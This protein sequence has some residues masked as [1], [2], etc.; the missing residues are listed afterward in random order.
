M[1]RTTHV[2][3]CP[4][5]RRLRLAARMNNEDAIVETNGDSPPPE[6][7]AKPVNA[8]KKRRAQAQ[9]AAQSKQVLLDDTV[10]ELEEGKAK[11]AKASKQLKQVPI[12]AIALTALTT[13]A[14]CR[15]PRTCAQKC[16]AQVR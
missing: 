6:A 5:Q 16:G 13:T 15:R 10:A 1:A 8:A 2:A 11:V 14:S 12:T 9:R 7:S 4:D 3:F